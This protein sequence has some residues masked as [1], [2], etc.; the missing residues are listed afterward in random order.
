MATAPSFAH[1]RTAKRVTEA[2]RKARSGES[3]R[4]G[5]RHERASRAPA[6]LNE[7]GWTP[8]RV[9]ERRAVDVS[10][11]LAP[12]TIE[13]VCAADLTVDEFVE[14]F[15]R[16]G[17]PVILTGL[18]AHWKATNKWKI[19][20]SERRRWQENACSSFL[21]LLYRKYRNQKFKCGEDDDGYS[22][23]MK[24]KYYIDYMLSTSDDS[25][26]YIFDS[27]F[28]DVSAVTHAARNAADVHA[29]A[30]R[31]GEPPARRLRGAADVRRRSLS[32]RDGE[33]PPAL[34][35]VRDGSST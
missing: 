27:S 25:P 5:R 35:L 28:A 14:R 4:G 3:L 24:L 33:A 12:D 10:A 7:C 11:E 1:K 21:Q 30:A 18:T 17:T 23:K 9:V 15:E 19:P 2:K 6:E 13:R 32:L 29:A 20:V 16:P 8:Q 34:P 22:V 31:Q 26:L